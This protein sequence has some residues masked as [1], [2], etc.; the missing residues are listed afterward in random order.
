[1][2]GAPTPNGRC[3]AGLCPTSVARDVNVDALGPRVVANR[4]LF[5]PL[6]LPAELCLRPS[7]S[8]LR[9]ITQLSPSHPPSIF[10]G[11]ELLPSTDLPSHVASQ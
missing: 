6:T 8:T 7:S 1:M 2:K 11:P 9:F 3:R 5:K 10:H 4:E